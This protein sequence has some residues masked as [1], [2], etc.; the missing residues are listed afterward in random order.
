MDKQEIEKKI[1]ELEQAMYQSDFWNDPQSAQEI[2]KEIEELKIQ[3]QSQ[4]L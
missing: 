2:I 1:Q 4:I 3:L